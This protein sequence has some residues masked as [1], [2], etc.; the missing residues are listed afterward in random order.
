MA[1][2]LASRGPVPA[3]ASAPAVRSRARRLDLD[4]AKGIAILQTPV[5]PRSDVAWNL[6]WRARA[7]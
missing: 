7:C 4:R 6:R 5:I 1:E 3:E 2:V